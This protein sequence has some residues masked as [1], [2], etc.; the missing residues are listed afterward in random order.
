MVEIQVP[1][2]FLCLCLSSVLQIGPGLNTCE[3]MQVWR[4]GGDACHWLAVA[5]VPVISA[6][7]QMGREGYS[8][9]LLG[10]WLGG[11][12]SLTRVSIASQG[13]QCLLSLFWPREPW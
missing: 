12:P 3:Q 11:M 9:K 10:L 4:V 6:P 8:L 1:I 2:F 7:W 13:K 5:A